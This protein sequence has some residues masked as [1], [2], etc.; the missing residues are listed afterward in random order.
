MSVAYDDREHSY[1][2]G[3][4]TIADLDRMP[5]DARYELVDGW[6]VLSPWLGIRHD[7][8]VRHLRTRLETA[9][10]CAGA[11][12]YVNGPVDV[13]TS[14]GIRVPD[15][16]VVDGKAARRAVER[17]ERAYQGVDLLLVVEV[18]SRNGSERTD[19]YEKPSEYAKTGIAQYWVV[20]LEPK[21]NI[22]VWTLAPG[23][24]VYRRV[25]RVFA[26]N[27]LEV[28]APVELAIDPA[29]LLSV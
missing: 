24:G 10:T 9:V 6:I 16:A 20:D 27:L 4:Y 26:G 14:T 7:H 5:R 13:F 19:R 29:G 11:D 2:H 15:V 3:P 22:T 8:A 18:V 21:P 25:D 28:R 17:D 1:R 23:H 12:L